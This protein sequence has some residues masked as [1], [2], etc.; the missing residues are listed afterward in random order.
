MTYDKYR[1]TKGANFHNHC[2]HRSNAFG[3]E[4]LGGL[5]PPKFDQGIWPVIKSRIM[6]DKKLRRLVLSG[7]QE[8]RLPSDRRRLCVVSLS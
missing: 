3:L 1:D 5:L 4:R 8:T 2:H 6:Q 7:T